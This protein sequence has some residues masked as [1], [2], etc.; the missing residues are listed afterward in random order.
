MSSVSAIPS[1]LAI[2]LFLI[3]ALPHSEAHAQEK[4]KREHVFLHPDKFYKKYFPKLKI[5]RT[6]LD[7]LYIKTYPNYLSVGMH[8]LS[9]SIHKNFTPNG[10]KPDNV[11]ASSKF[12]TNI[13]DIVGFSASYRFV[14][15]G[16][17]FLLKSGMNMHHDY[18]PSRYRTATIK[19]NS[20]AYSLQFKYIRIRGFTDINQP[21]NMEPNPMYAQRPDMVSKEFQF[22]GLYNFGWKKYSYIAPLNFSQRQIKSRAGFLLRAGAYYDQLAGDSMLLGKQQRPYYN[23]FDSVTTMRSLS[24]RIAP[25]IGGNLVFFKCVYVSMAAFVSADLFFYKYLKNTDAKADGNQ[26][27][28][29]VWDS[30]VSLGYQSKRLYAGLRYETE[31][32]IGELHNMRMNAAYTYTG[33]ELGYRFDAPSFV[34]KVYKKT[35]PPGM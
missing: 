12:R 13:S 9:P 3:M 15:F 6:P 2:S 33:I 35:M 5:K 34:K 14:S 29:F 25:G 17:A 28:I 24:I 1:F 19:Y 23:D 10:T 20:A 16:F 18:A 27:F 31:F 26:R 22:E 4:K 32:R 8:V 7:T 21:G 11:D 30:K